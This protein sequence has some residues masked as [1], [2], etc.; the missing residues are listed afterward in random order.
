MLN[1]LKLKGNLSTKLSN[2]KKNGVFWG[3]AFPSVSKEN[4]C[5]MFDIHIY[6]YK[7]KNRYNIYNMYIYINKYIHINIYIYVAKK[8]K[9]VP[10]L[11]LLI[12]QW[13]HGNSC[14][15]AHEVYIYVYIC[16]YMYIYIYLMFYRNTIKMHKTMETELSH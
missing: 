8:L 11:L 14:T 13:S 6:I 7:Y 12:R 9:Y 1:E 5:Y 15:W 10:S 3:K 2:W 16:I 4:S